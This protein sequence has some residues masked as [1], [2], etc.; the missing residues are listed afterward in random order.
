[1]ESV[2]YATSKTVHSAHHSITVQLAIIILNTQTSD[3]L[4]SSVT[5]PTVYN[6]PRPNFV[7]SV[8]QDSCQVHL[9][10]VS[11]IPSL[12]VSQ[13]IHQILAIIVVKDSWS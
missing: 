7:Q 10:S 1:M 12:T 2:N 6:A 13:Q 5:F 4:V 8:P 9:D 11:P 3:Q